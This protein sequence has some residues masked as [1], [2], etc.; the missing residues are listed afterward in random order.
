M[1]KVIRLSYAGPVVELD[2]TLS[3]V[4]PVPLYHQLSGQLE[5]AIRIGLLPKGAF[6]D[7]E[8]E[9]AERWQVSRPT[10]RRAIQSLVDH[11]LLVRRRGVGTQ[12]VSDQVRRPF[13]LSSL[14]DDL[15]ESGRRPVTRVLTLDRRAATDR[16]SVALGVSPGT[17]LVFIERCRSAG[18]Q[19]IAILRN[20]IIVDAAGHIT[21]EQLADNG[22]YA[23]IRERGVRPHS[24]LQTLGATAANVIDAGILGVSVGA[25]LLTMQRAMQDDT[26]RAIELGEH[27][28]DAAHYSVELSVVEP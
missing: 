15:T 12:V 18:P 2:I 7:N 6:L 23:L 9:L 3:R 16:A 22:L 11:G 25:P 24:A 19:R 13:R 26:G 8:L 17:E 1:D 5:D 4:S 28:Y 27:V 14:F 21:S 20:W 10:V